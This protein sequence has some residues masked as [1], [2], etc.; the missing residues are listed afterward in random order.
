MESYW[1]PVNELTKCVCTDLGEFP[2]PI[3]IEM[4]KLQ[5]QEMVWRQ[6]CKFKERHRNAVSCSA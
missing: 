2:T 3:W 4:C 5:A 6:W 1:A